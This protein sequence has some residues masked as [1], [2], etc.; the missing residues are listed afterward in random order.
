MKQ[1]LTAKRNDYDLGMCP[2]ATSK[3]LQNNLCTPGSVQASD[4]FACTWHW[5]SRRFRN[6]CVQHTHQCRLFQDDCIG[7]LSIRQQCIRDSQ[8]QRLI[9][10][11]H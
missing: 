9:F 8:W 5:Q 11:R 6:I 4:S 3:L 1:T 7:T 2:Y 10:D